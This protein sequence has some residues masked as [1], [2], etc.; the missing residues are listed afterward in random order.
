M[1][2]ESTGA[3]I[4]LHINIAEKMDQKKLDKRNLI[5]I[6]S[7]FLIL[8]YARY[9]SYRCKRFMKRLCPRQKMSCI[10]LRPR[11]ML[12]LTDSC[13]LAISWASVLALN[14][15]LINVFQNYGHTFSTY[16]AFLL[17]DIF[18]FL[19]SEGHNVIILIY[20]FTREIPFVEKTVPRPQFYQTMMILGPRRD[21]VPSH[22][23]QTIFQQLWSDK[24]MWDKEILQIS[25]ETHSKLHPTVTPYYSNSYHPSPNRTFPMPS[26]E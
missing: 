10:G 18:W 11:N 22:S 24:T 1:N 2:Q 13:N 21:K 25:Q 4:C 6:A 26:V 16:R 7:V 23:R 5:A 8:F 19:S 14:V 9:L 17:H 20:L 3:S 15:L 12:T